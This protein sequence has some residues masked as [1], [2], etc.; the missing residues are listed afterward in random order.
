[1]ANDVTLLIKL[2]D[3]VSGQVRKITAA[4]N[5]A[6]VAVKKLE[7]AVKRTGIQLERLR[8]K[9]V[10]ALKT[11]ADKAKNAAKSFGGFGKAAALA[12]A[13]A[14]AAAFAKFSFGAAGELQ[15]QTKSLEVLTG[16]LE[17][18]KGIIKDLK[19]FGAVTPF[20]SQELIE[21]SK[22]LK[23]FGFETEQ[24]VDVTK[25]LADVAGATGADLAGIATAFGQIQAKGRLQTEELLQLQERGVGIADELQKMYGMTG[26]E[27]SKALEKGQISAEA[28][29]VALIRLTEQGGKYAN[30]AVA[31]SDTLFGKLS[32]L[33]DAFITLGQNI[34]QALAPIFDFLITQTT[35]LINAINGIFDRNAAI[36]AVREREGKSRGRSQLGR[37][38]GSEEG[39]AAV[40][41][42]LKRIRSGRSI[43]TGS[44]KPP[45]IP[46]LLAGRTGSGS[47]SGEKADPLAA[48]KRQVEALKEGVLIAKTRTKEEARQQ[49]LLNKIAAL[50]RIRTDENA[51]VVDEAI[52]LT[53][54][55]FYQE[56]LQQKAADADAEKARRLAEQNQ[57]YQ[58]IGQTI[59]SGLVQGIQ[60]AITGAKS[61]GQSL[62]GILKSVG[63]IFLKAG[64]GTIGTG[65]EA[66]T[67]LLGALGFASGGFVDQPTRAVIG[68]GGESEYVIPSSKMN[69]AMGRYARGARGGAVIPDGPGGDASGGMAGGGGS[70]D[71]SYSVERINNVNYVT[72]AEFERGMAQ[73][74]KRGAELGRRNIYSDLVNK[75]S[76][77][78][79]V[80][81]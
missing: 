39:R 40:E 54:E 10:S 17:T 42:E 3:Q 36:N 33:Q 66:G 31:Q 15:R 53:G 19:A 30:G 46:E 13:A 41:A 5:K 81:V 9:G 34:G 21:T 80:G 32:T 1:M 11:I 76:V 59:Q 29:N 63:G 24:V 73:A 18:A 8:R 71:V 69:E 25:R 49:T 16:S 45:T 43:G 37:F 77:R 58:Q 50:T 38:M 6:E 57:L 65:G 4:S 68:E 79:R 14:G 27:F 44:A 61:L 7:R 60:D 12:A 2:R 51:A 48:L 23:A 74:A 56:G 47:G 78:S 20:T 52:K 62:S 70:I 67:G 72:A 26:E 28:A 75:R 55:L 35:R 22:R 64:I